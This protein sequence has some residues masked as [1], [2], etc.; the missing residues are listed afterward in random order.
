[1]AADPG[2]PLPAGPWRHVDR[3]LAGLES[4]LLVVLLLG[5]IAAGTA[6]ILM[7]NLA[8]AGI[9]GADPLM[10]VAVLW[11]ALLGA[12]VATR[13]RRHVTVDLLSRFLRPGLRRW[14]EAATHAFTASICGLIAWHAGR[15][16]YYEF[17]EPTLAF[18]GLP[19]W[20]AQA[21]LPIGFG[22]IAL[23]YL[24]YLVR[25]LVTGPRA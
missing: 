7:R 4:T 5:L 15:L 3:L 25:T 11:I 16:V 10:R 24:L 17:T 22:L 1:M 13:Q 8:D 21:I 18:A 9:A 19:V 12:M 14:T 6:Q 2:P 23:R 20:M